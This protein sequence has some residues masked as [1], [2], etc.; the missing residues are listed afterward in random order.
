VPMQRRVARDVEYSQMVE[1]SANLNRAA[2]SPPN[3]LCISLDD[4]PH[5]LSRK[6]S[7]SNLMPA[8]CLSLVLIDA[9]LFS[10]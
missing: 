10:A 6:Q 5:L 8:H 7:S 2:P 9:D 3:S 4:Q 1:P